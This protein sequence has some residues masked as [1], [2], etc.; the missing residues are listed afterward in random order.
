M[1]K[2]VCIILM[3]G[4]IACKVTGNGFE[5]VNLEE[6]CRQMK[7]LE[8]YEIQVDNFRQLSGAE[9]K[10]S[11][12]V[13]LAKEIKRVIRQDEVDGIVV[14]Q[15]TNLMEEVAFALDVL[16]KTDIPVICTGAMRPATAI[17]ADGPANLIDAVS[18]AASEQSRG[19]GVMVIM[20]NQI[21]S[22]QYVRKEHTLNPDAFIQNSC[23]D[24]WQNMYRASA[25]GRY[26]EI[27]P[28][29]KL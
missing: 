23:W 20:N 8:D 3:G 15:G 2:R 28:K 22:A 13:D 6:F 12:I 25:A 27:F 24:I 16:V 21:H 19:M 10:I 29:L 7:E 9:A 1:R 5:V 4:T 18:A 11:D 14:V 26:Q 17:G